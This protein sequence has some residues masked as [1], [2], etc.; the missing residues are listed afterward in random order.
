MSLGFMSL[1]P[2]SLHPNNKNWDQKD[3]LLLPI[4]T[5]MSFLIKWWVKLCRSNLPRRA[6]S[7]LWA[8]PAI[9]VFLETKQQGLNMNTIRP[10]ATTIP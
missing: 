2:G 1:I 9:L 8:I 3:P 4:G 6:D 7:G 5:I 10:R